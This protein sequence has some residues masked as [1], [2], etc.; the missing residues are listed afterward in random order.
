MNDIFHLIKVLLFISSFMTLILIF[1][2]S[3]LESDKEIN[4][5]IKC[6]EE[7]NRKNYEL[8]LDELSEDKLSILKQEIYK[9][10]I[11]L[12]ENAENSKIDKMNLK[13]SLQD[14]SHQLK[15]PLTSINILLDNIIDDPQMDMETRNR[16]IIRIKR[17]ITSI[18]FLVQSI[19][20]L[21]KFETNTISFIK[22][23]V[24]IKRMIDEVIDNVS[25][26]SDLK[27]VDI[28]VYN[29]CHNEIECDFRWQVEAL[30]N[31][32]KN[33]VSIHIMT[34]KFKSNVR[35]MNYTLRFVFKILEKVWIGKIL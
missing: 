27:N 12:K 14:I 19:L 24:S 20:K 18:T 16:F 22:E 15:T 5:I 7:I 30:T 2:Y 25:N 9:T 32:L 17:E 11:M 29:N 28:E 23:S 4:K 6:I 13:N 3:H 33:A 8:D 35:R 1:L 34:I 10:T 21:S 26:L 31:I